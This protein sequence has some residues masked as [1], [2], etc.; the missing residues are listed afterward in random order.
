M[1]DD[2]EQ[3]LRDLPSPP[4]D[5]AVLEVHQLIR[6]F[7][8]AVNE[9]IKGTCSADGLIQKIRE[10]H[11]SF[12]RAVRSTAPEFRPLSK[13]R[14]QMA[15]S[16]LNPSFI[17]E[18]EHIDEHTGKVIYVD[19]VMDRADGYVCS[20]CTSQPGRTNVFA[21]VRRSITR[22]L[23]DNY[24][25]QVSK[26]YINDFVRLWERPAKNLFADIERR[27]I[28]HLNKSM[29]EFFRVHDTGGL[30]I[31][32]QYDNVAYSFVARW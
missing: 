13:N 14:D 4:S 11:R 19:E 6:A 10:D 16:Y 25:F 24:S 20:S 5:D 12:R 8:R 26:E 9:D 18:E 2:T 32:V 15:E 29:S 31:A 30:N 3:A 27:L 22:E 1:L 21:H 23:P 28:S 17:P 7:S